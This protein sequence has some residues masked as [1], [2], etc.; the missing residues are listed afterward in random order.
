MPSRHDDSK[1]QSEGKSVQ[2]WREKE[3]EKKTK[4]DVR[5]RQIMA[6]KNNTMLLYITTILKVQYYTIT[7][8]NFNQ[9]P[10]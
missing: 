10:Y 8:G 4:D 5:L 3:I 7:N 1:R 9:L 6:G 2:F